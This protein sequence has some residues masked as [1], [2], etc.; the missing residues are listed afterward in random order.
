MG[1]GLTFERLCQVAQLDEEEGIQ[2]L[3]EVLRSGWLCEDK[4]T[5]ASQ[6]EACYFFPGEMV[7]A[8]VYQEAGVV[9]QRLI[10]RRVVAVLQEHDEHDQD[11]ET[12]LSQPTPF[13]RYASAETRETRARHVL[14]GAASKERSGRV[15]QRLRLV[16]D[17]QGGKLG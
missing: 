16:R 4:Q 15:I 7:C 9:R 14:T 1:E 12:C 10:Q 6:V 2:A 5:E 11:E 13:D 3:E 17:E 8:V